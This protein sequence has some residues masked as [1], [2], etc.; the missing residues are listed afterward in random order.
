MRGLDESGRSHP[1][2]R[3]NPHLL[4]ITDPGQPDEDLVYYPIEV[5]PSLLWRYAG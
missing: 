4:T 1:N 2:Q 5:S 3:C